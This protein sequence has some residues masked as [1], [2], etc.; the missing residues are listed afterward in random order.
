M[1]ILRLCAGTLFYL[2]TLFIQTVSRD[3]R[4]HT[5]HCYSKF[6]GVEAHTF[7]FSALILFFIF[8]NI[9]EMFH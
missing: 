2:T 3:G 4:H 6:P 1:Q 5:T 8:K 7:W 9:L